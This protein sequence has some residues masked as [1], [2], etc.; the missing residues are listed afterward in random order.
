MEH[1]EEA[2]L[3]GNSIDHVLDM[4]EEES[5]PYLSITGGTGSGKTTKV[6]WGL[7]QRG[8]RVLVAQPYI[9][10]VENTARYVA[11]QVGTPLGEKVGYQTS[12]GS[13]LSGETRLCFATDG[14]DLNRELFGENPYDILVIDEAH[15][16]NMNQCVLEPRMVGEELLSDQKHPL[17]T[18]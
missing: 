18:G 5:V 10:L 15:L 11:Q 7:C 17:V 4:I 14:L 12:L 13:C 6:P 16:G 8:Y 2:P 3:I 9:K 1:D